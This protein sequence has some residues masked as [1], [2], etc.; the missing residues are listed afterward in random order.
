MW[1]VVGKTSYFG[2]IFGKA[3]DLVAVAVLVIVPNVQYYIFTIFGND[4]CVAVVNRRSGGS[5]DIR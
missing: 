1:L 3:N 2:N 4:C 5:H